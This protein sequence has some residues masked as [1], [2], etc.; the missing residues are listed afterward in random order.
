MRRSGRV[1][2][3]VAVG[4]VLVGTSGP[5][6]AQSDAPTPP[7]SP[8]L[9]WKVDAPLLAAGATLLAVGAQLDVAVRDVP[10]QG[11]DRGDIKWSFD[12]NYI[13]EVSTRADS[14][15]DYYRDAAVA[16]PMI[17]AFASQPSGT[18]MSGTLRRSLVYAEAVA[19]AEGIALVVK[20]GA[21]RPR[22]YTYLAANE[23]PSNSAYD[24][25]AESSFRSMPSG[26]ATISF[27]AAAFAMTDHVLTRP[28]ASWQEQAGTAF[29]GGF[30]AGITAGLR[31]EGGLHFPSD[32]MVGGLIG[33]TCGVT[34]PL[35][36]RYVGPTERRKPMPPGRAWW[37][38][39]LGEVAGIG[40]G[41]L[42]AEAY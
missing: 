26:H 24:V 10:P 11:L 41:F 18:R 42:A 32:S 7:V 35:V 3:R 6:R 31:V 34:I 27:C 36:H 38:A 5:I 15:S 19:V 8:E 30:L 21:D 16:Y 23:R 22:P 28:Q 17:L 14:H 1:V 2:L 12:R 20:R 39:I 29:V 9:R 4:L 13:G 25:T 33:M 37:H 40:A